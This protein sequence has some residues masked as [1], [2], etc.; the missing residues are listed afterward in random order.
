MHELDTANMKSMFCTFQ[1][2][3][4]SVFLQ[5]Y[6]TRNGCTAHYKNIRTLFTI[7]YNVSSTEFSLEL[8]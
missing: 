7:Y 2:I 4:C 6:H 8:P 1:G 3:V 5:I